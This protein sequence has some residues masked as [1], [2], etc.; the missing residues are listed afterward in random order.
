[1]QIPLSTLQ[2]W[3]S[4][5]LLLS[6]TLVSAQEQPDA[7]E[8][9]QSLIKDSIERAFSLRVQKLNQ[10][11]TANQLY[12]AWT[13]LLPSMSLSSGR[14]LSNTGSM[15]EN[16]TLSTASSRSD[17]LSLSATWKIWDG[18]QNIRNVRL[19]SLDQD[20]QTLQSDL[21]VQ[22]HI[23]EVVNQYLGLQELY[24]RRATAAEVVKNARAFAEEAEE[25]V[26]L[27]GKTRIEQMD[28]EIQLKNFENDA[29]ELEYSINAA[30]RQFA[31]LLNLPEK[32]PI[33]TIDVL[34]IKPYFMEGFEKALPE[35]RKM[36]EQDRIAS[37]PE[38]RIEGLRVDRTLSSFRQSTLGY[39][40]NTSFTLSQD[41]D[42]DGYVVPGTSE[43]LRKS[44][45][46]TTA[47]FSL[48]WTVWDWFATHRDI[49]N[50]Y[51]DLEIQRIEFTRKNRQVRNDFL[52]SLEQ[53]DTLERTIEN[54][55]MV[56]EQAISQME[57]TRA[58]YQMGR[59][60]LLQAQTSSERLA[61]ARVS[62]I[63]R[64]RTQYVAAAKLLVQVGQ[65]VLPPGLQSEL[66]DPARSR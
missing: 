48:S 62:L 41:Y 15:D 52:T 50:T 13:S 24:V 61:N 66:I 36:A 22:N 28:T 21:E 46:S 31:I 64:L 44:V 30:E 60:G 54:A 40:P 32:K 43:A 58:M 49:R 18:Y 57:Y 19:S 35:I 23:V 17:S 26:K 29:Q 14:T 65:G 53:Y 6:C 7:G 25:L 9:L 5:L 3:I 42:L 12:T 63:T 11:K 16:G 55:R 56:L 8:S 34:K 10:D 45:P 38:L 51:K 27:G 2:K 33:P 59:I 37:A 47:T 1:M 20:I 4:G 39:L